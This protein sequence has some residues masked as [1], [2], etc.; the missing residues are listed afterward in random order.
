MH[1]GSQKEKPILRL[2][3]QWVDENN[4]GGVARSFPHKCMDS[5]HFAKFKALWN[6]EVKTGGLLLDVANQW[7]QQKP[8]L[9]TGNSKG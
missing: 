4:Q 8:G 3:Y 1:L 5:T 7:G 2:C 9:G 6:P